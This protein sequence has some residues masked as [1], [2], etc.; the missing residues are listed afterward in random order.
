MKKKVDHSFRI[1]L[2]IY[3]ILSILLFDPKLFTGGDNAVYVILGEAIAA[4]KGYKNI[5]QP[6]EPPHTQYPPGFPL[7]LSF[8]ILIF[9]SNIILLKML[10]FFTGIAGLFFMSGIVSEVFKEKTKLIMLFFVSIPIF[11]IY[12]HWILSEIPF[13]CFSLGAI[14][15]ARKNEVRNNLV[16][17]LVSSVFSVGSFFIRTAGISLIIAFAVYLIIK[18]RYLHLL[19]YCTIFLALFIP[20]EVR[21]AHIPDNTGY[22]A[23]LLAKNPYQMEAG[24]IGLIDL[25][26]RLWDNFVLYT[27]KILPQT[28]LP[29]LKSELLQAITGAILVILCIIGFI[30]R[31]SNISLIELYFIFAV[32][33]LLAWPVVWSS[34]RFLLPIIPLMIIYI[35]VALFWFQGRIKAKKLVLIFTVVV[36]MLNVFEIIPQV[37]V[38][39]MNKFAY[40][41]NNRYAGYPVDWR[42][43]FETIEWI[44]RNVSGDMV[45]MARKPEFVYLLSRHKSLCYPFTA[46]NK[47]VTEAIRNADYII[48]DGFQWTG[49]TYR[50]LLPVLRQAPENYDIVYKTRPPEFFLLKVLGK[51]DN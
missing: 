51:T 35:F 1:F 32:G 13:L 14:Y 38:S 28:V 25:I 46:D 11:I 40:L 9:N 30:R 22:L 23:Q 20:W 12:N 17:F 15:F 31:L 19:L 33:V 50:Y 48:L 45:I 16:F 36:A 24:R 27:F 7:L 18:K 5:Y 39:M 42:H 8:G 21:N 29:L 44:D 49:T 37:R 10:I 47:K 26:G 43:Y 4:G 41:K 6:D 2:L 3:V 34:D